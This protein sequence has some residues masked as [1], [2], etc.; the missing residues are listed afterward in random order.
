VTKVTFETASLADAIKKANIVAPS[1]G[2]AFD[3][4]G[5]IVLE[6]LPDDGLVLFRATNKDV[7]HTEWVQPLSIEGEATTW[8]LSS[9][10]V[11]PV[12]ASLPIGSGK[13]TVLE[14]VQHGQS[15]RIEMKSGRTKAKFFLMDTAHYPQ[16]EIFDPS[17]L[18]VVNDLGGKLAL[19]EWAAGLKELAPLCGININGEIV[20][21]TD[22][23]KLAVVPLEIPGLENPVT[24]P[25]GMLAQILRQTGEVRV[26]FTEHQML[27]MPN[28]TTQLRLVTFAGDYPTMAK[29]MNRE[30]PFSLSVKKDELLAIVNRATL[31]APG[32]RLPLLNLYIGKESIAAKVDGPESAVVDQIDIPGQ[33]Q[34]PRV[35]IKVTPKML[36]DIL[37]H[38]PNDS[39]TIHYDVDKPEG[40]L[41]INGGSGFECW[42][43]ARKSGE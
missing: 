37:N 31:A 8:R 40:V 4:A 30:R 28:D 43:V 14:Q 41:Y 19:V 38:A 7:F 21:A 20:K 1:H 33:A 25:A 34:H 16:W 27:L 5:G 32:D 9:T 29:L 42:M 10:L 11:A 17:E 3:E 13:T 26:G 2:K 18:T 24:I 23:Y 12:I 35:N 39:V 22:R 15:W 6:I 36:T